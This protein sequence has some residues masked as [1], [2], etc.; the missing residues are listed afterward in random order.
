MSQREGSLDPQA[1]DSVSLLPHLEAKIRQTH[2]LAR[3]L[4]KYAEQLLQEYVQHQGDPFGLPGFSPPRL[5]VAGLSA[6]APGHAGLPLPERLR[7]DA[8]A[9]AALPPLLDVVRRHQAELNPRVPRLLRRLE[10]AARQARALGAAVET[11][12]AALGST[13]R[14]PWPEP[15][16]TNAAAAATAATTTTTTSAAGVF[17]AKM[18]GLR[19][20]GLYSEWVSRT[21]GDLSQL[22]PEGP[23]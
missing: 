20:C 5:P 15:S 21:E 12:L 13:A 14:G 2:S 16:A 22:V 4:T 17:P 10:D 3:L 7:L 9:L 8:A 23:A 19:V 18:L 6:P 1:D 11:V